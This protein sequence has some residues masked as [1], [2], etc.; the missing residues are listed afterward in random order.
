MLIGL[1]VLT[2]LTVALMAGIFYAWSI[3][4]MRGFAGLKDREFIRAMQ[5]ANRAIQNPV[6]FAAFF[7]APVLLVLSAFLYYGHSTRFW[8]LAAAALIYSTD[9]FGVTV[10][11]SVP[12]N[13]A[14]DRLD[15]ETAADE[16][17]ARARRNFER[18]WNNLNLLRAVSA[19][20]AVVLVAIACLN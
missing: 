10:F 3:S 4:V 15:S 13:R 1:L 5:S 14:L 2:N 9:T 11:G 7:G 20:I 6:F 12:L 19:T 18:R 16:E 8:L 17:V